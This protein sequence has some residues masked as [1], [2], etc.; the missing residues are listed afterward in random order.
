MG[1]DILPQLYDDYSLTVDGA[2]EY[3][4]VKCKK[5][6]YIIDAGANSGLYSC[7]AVAVGCN[8]FACD[9]DSNAIDLLNRQKKIC[10]DNIIVIGKGLS[11]ED[12]S[13]EF[14]QSDSYELS[15]INMPR[16]TIKKVKIEIAK[17]D[18]LVETGVIPRVD[19]IKADV[20]GA[21]RDLL[22]GAVKTL[23][24]MHLN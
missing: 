17:L 2:Y 1:E 19:L 23:K 11:N 4:H 21:E 20:E 7:Y 13:I 15:S 16:G 24:N 14:Y 3:N 10:P 8:V 9:P 12:G 6:D 5:G 18:T 22:T